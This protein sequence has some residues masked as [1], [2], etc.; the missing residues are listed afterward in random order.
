MESMVYTRYANIA[1]Q[2]LNPVL[3]GKS[4]APVVV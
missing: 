2:C 1:V 4:I 3:P